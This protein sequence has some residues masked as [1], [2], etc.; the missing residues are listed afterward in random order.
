MSAARYGHSTIDIIAKRLFPNADPD[1][2]RTNMRFLLLALFLGL[3]VC[4]LLGSMLWLLNRS[5]F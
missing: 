3:M 2:R 1:R 5:R 4:G